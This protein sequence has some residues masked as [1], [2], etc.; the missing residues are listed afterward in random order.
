MGC[1][2]SK[3]KVKDGAPNA[4]GEDGKQ[5]EDQHPLRTLFEAVGEALAKGECAAMQRLALPPLR[6]QGPWP[7]PGAPRGSGGGRHPMAVAWEGVASAR[8]LGAGG[9]TRARLPHDQCTALQNTMRPSWA[10]EGKA[11][12][13]VC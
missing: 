11:G 6:M 2:Q 4:S 13:R 8:P 5:Q 7:S 12:S 9:G 10:P 3:P 1:A